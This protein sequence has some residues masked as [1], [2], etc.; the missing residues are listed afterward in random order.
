MHNPDTMPDAP[1][2]G[3]SPLWQSLV[4]FGCG[5]V[6][7][8]AMAHH[9]MGGVMPST[10]AQGLL[11]G[12]GHPVI[13]P[14]HLLFVL[15]LGVLCWRMDLGWR[16]V[17]SFLGASLLGIALHLAS[18]AVPGNESL[19]ALS[20]LVMGISLSA[21]GRAARRA[22]TPVAAMAGVFHGYAYGEPI[23]GAESGVLLAYLLGTRY[24]AVTRR[25]RRL[26]V[27][28]NPGVPNGVG[29]RVREKAFRAL[30]SLCG[31]GFL[32]LSFA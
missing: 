23:V 27:R 22:M 10:F 14:D 19:V 3:V 20:L 26:L 32:L 7:A 28:E 29:A 31:A 16:A 2:H 30:V 6:A 11:S 4:L 25:R 24:R 13:G 21:G 5:G 1:K 17:A 8:S 9:V 18:I 15:A 12:L